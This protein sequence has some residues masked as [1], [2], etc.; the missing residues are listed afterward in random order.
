MLTD[1]S[2]LTVV[3]Y[4]CETLKKHLKGKRISI[5]DG[6]RVV[7]SSNPRVSLTDDSLL[8]VVIYNCKKHS[9]E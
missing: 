1:D 9:K 3:I 5:I 4:N 8:T 7:A 2:L 6:E